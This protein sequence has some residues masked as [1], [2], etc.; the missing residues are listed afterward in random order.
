MVVF[1]TD[2]LP[3]E[4]PSWERVLSSMNKWRRNG[5]LRARFEGRLEVALDMVSPESRPTCLA[6]LDAIG[7][8]VV[9]TVN[10]AALVWSDDF[11]LFPDT[12]PRLMRE[13]GLG[14]RTAVASP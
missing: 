14:A 10:P 3:D 12:W 2:H 9:E 13:L 11:A 1:L 5:G 4:I 6:W 7:P 8:R